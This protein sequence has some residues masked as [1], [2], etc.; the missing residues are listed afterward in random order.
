MQRWPHGEAAIVDC[1]SKHTTH[2]GSV[3]TGVSCTTIDSLSR[4]AQP[5]CMHHA[6]RRRQLSDGGVALVRSAPSRYTKTPPR[7]L[8][9]RRFKDSAAERR[10]AQGRRTG[11]GLDSARAVSASAMADGASSEYI[12]ESIAIARCGT[13]HT[14]SQNI[15][16]EGSP[17]CACACLPLS[18]DPRCLLRLSLLLGC[19]LLCR[20]LLRRRMLFCRMPRCRLLRCVLRCVLRCCMLRF[21][22]LILRSVRQSVG[23]GTARTIRSI[24]PCKPPSDQRHTAQE[25]AQQCHP[26][27]LP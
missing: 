23:A 16:H 7:A 14:T 5:A 27:D 1:R 21:P 24:A 26:R 25:R 15:A 17:G 20:F 19:R 11:V 10:H 9:E 12:C 18:L 3:P 4:A 8:M 22:R 13:Q 2:I 6:A